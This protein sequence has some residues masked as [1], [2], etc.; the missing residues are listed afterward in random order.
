MADDE[1]FEAHEGAAP[2]TP[3]RRAPPRVDAAIVATTN[4]LEEPSLLTRP[5]VTLFRILVRLPDEGEAEV[6]RRFS[7][8]TS[9]HA[10]LAE[11]PSSAP[12]PPLPPKLLLNADAD[13]AE[14]YLDLDAYLRSLLVSDY[15]SS[16]PL[17]EFL[18]LSSKQIVRYGVRNYEYDS[19]QSEGN[20]YIRNSDL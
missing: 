19:S 12:L 16:A 20:R 13:I 8:F 15:A 4:Q 10:Q 6:L 2:S 7:D 9:L 11:L 1:L 17:L 18:G 5:I 3:P 14:R